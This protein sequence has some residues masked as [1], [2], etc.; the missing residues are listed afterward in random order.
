MSQEKKLPPNYRDAQC[1][2]NCKEITYMVS[3]RLG[4]CP[5]FD[6]NILLEKTC[7][8]WEER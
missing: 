4:Y 7:D 5:A 8:E 2:G 1:C 6:V 3:D